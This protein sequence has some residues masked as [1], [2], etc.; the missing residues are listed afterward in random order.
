MGEDRL[1]S[2]ERTVMSSQWN[3]KSSLKPKHRDLFSE[4][5]RHS[6]WLEVM[7]S[8]QRCKENKDK[9]QVSANTRKET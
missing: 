7:E 3:V 4:E 6:R 9:K 5:I 2:N 1:T 8:E